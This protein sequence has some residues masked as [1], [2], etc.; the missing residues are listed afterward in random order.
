VRSEQAP[1][2]QKNV[3]PAFGERNAVVTTPTHKVPPKQLYVTD[4]SC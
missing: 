1:G 3:D 2:F 4:E